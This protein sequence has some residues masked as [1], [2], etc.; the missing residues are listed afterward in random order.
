MLRG[1]KDDVSSFV[2]NEC[3]G[4]L[5]CG[6]R[7][8]SIFGWD[9]N[10]GDYLFSRRYCHNMEVTAVD[11]AGYGGSIVVSGSRDATVAVW[12]RKM[13]K[14]NGLLLANQ[15]HLIISYYLF[16]VCYIFIINLIF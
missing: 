4:I 5:V 2:V 14:G 11:T 10:T 6:A 7:D 13:D 3:T 12:A 9:A 1:P 8:K 16:K 15:V